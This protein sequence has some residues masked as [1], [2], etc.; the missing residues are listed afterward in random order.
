MKSLIHYA[1]F[2][3]LIASIATTANATSF[4]ISFLSPT[5][6]RGSELTFDYGNDQ[7]VSVKGVAGKQNQSLTFVDIQPR[8]QVVGGNGQGLEVKSSNLHGFNN[9]NANNGIF[10]MALFDFG[11]NVSLDSFSLRWGYDKSNLSILALTGSDHLPS[12]TSMTWSS[13]LAN[14]FENAGGPNDYK[15]IGLSSPTTVN[16][17]LVARYWLIGA[18]NEVFGGTSIGAKCE[19]FRLGNLQFSVVDVSEIPLPAAAWLFLTGLAGLGLAKKRSKKNV[20]V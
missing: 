7:R 17:S 1:L 4:N 12:I 20:T 16:G 19:E 15:N 6:V 3:I 5:D 14:G 18:F 11:Q 8:G 2:S 13:L 9:G 10:E